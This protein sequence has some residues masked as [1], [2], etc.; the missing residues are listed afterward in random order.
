MK[1]F[2]RHTRFFSTS[3]NDNNAFTNDYM[4][5]TVKPTIWARLLTIQYVLRSTWC[6]IFI[7]FLDVTSSRTKNCL[8]I[9][10][11][12]ISHN[13]AEL[14]IKNSFW[15]VNY[16][17][18]EKPKFILKIVLIITAFDLRIEWRVI[19]GDLL[20]CCSR[21]V[22]IWMFFFKW[23]LDELMIYHKVSLRIF[24][25]IKLSVFPSTS[26]LC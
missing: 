6:N 1:P 2:L 17:W 5:E 4:K 9:G 16:S 18:W 24:F 10:N 8:L 23:K 7:V 15:C 13:S 22:F 11:L 12:N 3:F 21:I 25:C 26:S 19:L 14:E 20:Y